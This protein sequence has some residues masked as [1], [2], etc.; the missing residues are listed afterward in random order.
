VETSEKK[1]K[2]CH[3]SKSHPELLNGLKKFGDQTLKRSC[4]KNIERKWHEE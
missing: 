3:V 1:Q 2:D 4:P